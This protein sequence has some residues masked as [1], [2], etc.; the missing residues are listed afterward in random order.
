MEFILLEIAGV[1]SF[2]MSSN[3]NPNEPSADVKS[4]ARSSRMSLKKSKEEVYR[5]ELL[6]LAREKCSEEVRNF[7]QCAAKEGMLVVIYCREHNR[8]SKIINALNSFCQ[9]IVETLI[10]F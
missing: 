7:G 4:D 5:K 3:T 1:N 6:A 2:L 9:L 8:K 10:N